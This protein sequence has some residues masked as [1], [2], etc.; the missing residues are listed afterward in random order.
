LAAGVIETAALALQLQSQGG[1]EP[2]P[3]H[4]QLGRHLHDHLSIRLGRVAIRDRRRFLELFAPFFNGSTMRSLR[5]ELEPSVA[6]A[7]GLPALYLHFVAAAAEDSGFAL[8]RDALRAAQRRDFRGV[9]RNTTRMPAAIPGIA[10]MMY[11]RFARDRLAFPSGAE[12]YLHVDF[13]QPAKPV[14]RVFMR[15]D[16][17]HVD[18]DLEVD[19]LAIAGPATAQLREAWFRNNLQRVAEIEFF[20]ADVIRDGWP[21]N[22]YDIYHG[23]GT[24]RMAHRP[25]DGPVGP[26]LRIF[27]SDNVYAL[28]SSVFPSM[29]AANPTFTIMALGVRL[30]H[31]LAA[32]R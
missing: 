14:N 20:A 9:M 25:E 32:R 12:V 10:E 15:D 26:D 28:S 30:A 4:A 3:G 17:V 7:L 2:V 5:L 11:W 8:V 1:L 21:V 29:G 6:E 24:T 16:R 27:G 31:T 22:I 13:E 19:P 18:W 23:A